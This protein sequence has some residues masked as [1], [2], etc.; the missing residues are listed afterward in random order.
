VENVDL[1]L[2]SLFPQKG[3]RIIG[4]K[5]RTQAQ[6]GQQWRGKELKNSWEPVGTKEEEDPLL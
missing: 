3:A 4:G 6:E 5:G 2:L 1:D